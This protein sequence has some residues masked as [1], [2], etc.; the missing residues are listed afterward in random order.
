MLRIPA[1]EFAEL[2]GKHAGLVE[3]MSQ[4]VAERAQQNRAQYEALAAV[5]SAPV[6]QAISRAGI[7]KRFWRLLGAGRM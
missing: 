4:L 7:L 2:L 6:E 3:Q 1:P 5:D